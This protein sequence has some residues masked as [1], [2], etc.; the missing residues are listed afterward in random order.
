MA[1]MANKR[2]RSPFVVDGHEIKLI[3]DRLGLTQS[4]LAIDINTTPANL[5]RIEGGLQQPSLALRGRILARL[6][7][8]LDDIA[9]Q[10][11]TAS[12]TRTA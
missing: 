2:P 5:C 11:P 7:V 6:G 4:Q 9:T 1:N 10:R 12:T 8:T 3:R